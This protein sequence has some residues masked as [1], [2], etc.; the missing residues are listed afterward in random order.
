MGGVSLGTI[1]EEAGEG[2]GMVRWTI[3][4]RLNWWAEVMQAPV[5]LM[6]RVLVSSIKSAPDAS[7]ARKKTGTC[8]RSREDRRVVDGSK[9]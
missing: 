2:A 1:L 6:F 8:R 3:W 4:S 7:V 5:E 9:L